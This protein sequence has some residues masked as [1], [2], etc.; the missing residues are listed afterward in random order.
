MMLLKVIA[1]MVVIGAVVKV[2]RR[3]KIIV[4]GPNYAF[5]R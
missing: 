1:V 5:W 4:K 2:V 3:K